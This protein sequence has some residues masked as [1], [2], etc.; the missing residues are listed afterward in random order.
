ME[1]KEYF[2]KSDHLVIWRPKGILDAAKIHEF[3]H[4]INESSKTRDPHFHRFFDLTKIAGI[5]VKYD[6]L[7]PIAKV[8]KVYYDTKLEH[9]VKMAFLVNNP[10]SYGMARMYQG[11]SDVKNVEF[12]IFESLEEVS[13]YLE[14]NVSMLVE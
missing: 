2:F 11:I 3:I 7:H 8:R 10:I 4:F 9:R 14:V 1:D 12:K 13:E 5:S 6:E